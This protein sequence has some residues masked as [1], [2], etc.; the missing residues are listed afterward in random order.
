MIGPLVL[1]AIGSIGVGFIPIPAVIAGVV[2]TVAHSGPHPAWLPF[3][4][5]LIAAAGIVLA[6]YLYGVYRDVPRRIG[7]RFAALRRV[8]EAKWGWD[9][10]FNWLARRAVVEGSR[11][12]LWQRIDV[13]VIDAAVNG[14]AAYAAEMARASRAVQSGL[15][16]GYVLLIL[17][18]AV[19]LLAYLLW[20]PR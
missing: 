6:V 20:L 9:D 11:R 7:E 3:L 15:V 17:G 12:V 8:F 4:A 16:R 14:T 1:L 2:G 19:A 5:T 10:A 18:G 13:G